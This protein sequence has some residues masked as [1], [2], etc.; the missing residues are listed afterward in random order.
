MRPERGD[1]N[2]D[3][4]GRRKEATRIATKTEEMRCDQKSDQDGKT[5]PEEYFEYYREAKQIGKEIKRIEETKRIR[6]EIKRIEIARR[7]F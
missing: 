5:E 7:T 2:S 3:H 4:D 1:Q 6:K